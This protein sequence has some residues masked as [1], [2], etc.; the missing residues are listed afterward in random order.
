MKR[1]IVYAILSYLCITSLSWAACVQ[2]NCYNGKGTYTWAVGQ[3][4]GDK[5]IGEFKNSKRHGQGTYTQSNGNIYVGQ[6]KDG[7]RNGQGTYYWADGRVWKGNWKDNECPKC[8]VYAANSY[9]GSSILKS[10]FNALAYSAR[11]SIQRNLRYLGLYK[12]S[13][14]GL[15]GKRTEEALRAYNKKYFGNRSLSSNYNIIALLNSV[16]SHTSGSNSSSSTT[17][18]KSCSNDL[19]L[20]TVTQLCNKAIVYKNNKKE[21]SSSYSAKPYV[22]EAK[23]NGLTCG[24]EAQVSPSG[25][26]KLDSHKEFCK[27]IGF[28]PGT[29]KFGDCVMKLMD[30]D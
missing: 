6:F 13:I 24:V 2:G 11:I 3:W 21:W 8:K 26:S 10:K 16:R 20:C 17:T 12:S 14:A 9:S 22:D 30:K 23:K 7:N 19:S 25:N 15:Y 28:T 29:E 5:Y 18:H 27:E 1:L 4:K